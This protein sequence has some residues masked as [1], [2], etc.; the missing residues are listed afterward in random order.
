MEALTCYLTQIWLLYFQNFYKTS[1]LFTFEAQSQLSSPEKILLNFKYL[2]NFYL[3]FI[4]R[5]TKKHLKLN[6]YFLKLFRHLYNDFKYLLKGCLCFFY[7]KLTLFKEMESHIKFYLF[8]VLLY[9]NHQLLTLPLQI[10]KKYFFQRGSCH[11]C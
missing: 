7:C 11:G 5:K 8:N 6:R 2:S 1:N 3:Q 10:Y 4:Q 9:L